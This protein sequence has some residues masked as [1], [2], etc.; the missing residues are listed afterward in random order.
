GSFLAGNMGELARVH[1]AAKVRFAAFRDAKAKLIEGEKVE[2][3]D[4]DDWV[5]LNDVVGEES[6]TLEWFDKVKSQ[7][8][9]RPH[10]DRLSFR[11]ERLLIEHKRWADIAGMY[12]D[13]VAK[14]EQEHQFYQMLPKVPPPQG[15]DE[16]TR[17]M[18][19]ETPR[20]M[21]RDKIGN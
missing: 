6:R 17:K 11:L 20:K 18:M 1:P 10:L 2:W 8:R 15:V 7:P 5:V 21:F 4:L 12:P 3:Q 9:W 16:E 19:E 14:L 13:P